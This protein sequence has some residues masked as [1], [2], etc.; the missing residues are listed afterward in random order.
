MNADPDGVRRKHLLYLDDIGTE[1]LSV[2]YGER[3]MVFPEIVDEAEKRGKLLLVT[4][5]LNPTELRAKY[6]ERTLDRLRAITT[7]VVFKGE[8]LRGVDS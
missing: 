3:R 5:N 4:T 2:R 6:G 7:A 8:S 1:D